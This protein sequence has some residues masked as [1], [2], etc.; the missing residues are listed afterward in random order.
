MA[1]AAAFERLGPDPRDSL[2]PWMAMRVDE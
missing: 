1:V 2:F